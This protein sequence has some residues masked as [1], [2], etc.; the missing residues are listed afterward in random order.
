LAGEIPILSEHAATAGG[1]RG[2]RRRSG[3]PTAGLRPPSGRPDRPSAPVAHRP[4]GLSRDN[5]AFAAERCQEWSNLHGM[6]HHVVERDPAQKG[7]VVLAGR[8]V[9]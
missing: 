7:F 3:Q 6:R 8:W 5:G 2:P 9:V 1:G 4:S